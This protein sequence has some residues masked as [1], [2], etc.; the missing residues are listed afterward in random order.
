MIQLWRTMD[1]SSPSSV[2][3]QCLDGTDRFDIGFSPDGLSAAAA[4][5]QDDTVTVL[6][7]K[8]GTTQLI[9]DTG[10]HV[11]GVRVAESTVVVVVCGAVVTW[12]LPIGAHILGARVNSS[13]SI[14]TTTFDHLASIHRHGSFSISPGLNYIA[15]LD[16]IHMTRSW[17]VSA[18]TSL[19]GSRIRPWAHLAWFT[20]DGRKLWFLG[21]RRSEGWAIVR[22]SE[23]GVTK[24]EALDPAKGP[25]GG[26]P[27]QSPYGCQVMDD[28][29]ILNST[30]KRLLWL[31]PRWRSHEHGMSR[32]WSGRF[33]ALLHAA[34][35]EVV[36]LELLV[37]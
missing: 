18:M 10:G 16:R 34:L 15:G 9:V 7:L 3:T 26:F 32:V 13:D 14:R 33:L 17:D 25:S 19:M 36:I 2:P 20:P 12:N 11:C 30:G 28:G 27:W 35:P 24:L 5:L 29:W 8:S 6:D 4:R 1:S 23:S 31:S 37:E 22:D 21:S